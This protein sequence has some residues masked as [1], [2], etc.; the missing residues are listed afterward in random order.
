VQGADEDTV[1]SAAE[2]DDLF[3]DSGVYEVLS[4]AD[5]DLLTV[6]GADWGFAEAYAHDPECDPPVDTFWGMW[7]RSCTRCSAGP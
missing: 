6:A 4:E 1:L 2:V 7:A 3:G 5:Y